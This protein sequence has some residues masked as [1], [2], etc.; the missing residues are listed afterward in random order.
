MDLHLGGEV[1]GGLKNRTKSN[2]MKEMRPFVA[3]ANRRRNAAWQARRGEVSGLPL[4]SPLVVAFR[5]A[6]V[7]KRAG[8]FGGLRRRLKFHSG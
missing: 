4:L 3:A 7:A 6:G 2:K 5:E 1:S 8:P